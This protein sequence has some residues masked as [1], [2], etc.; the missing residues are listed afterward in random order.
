MKALVRS[1][2]VLALIAAAG[3]VAVKLRGPDVAGGGS[4]PQLEHME[5]RGLSFVK[6]TEEVAVAADATRATVDFPF[7]NKTDR[8]LTIAKVEKNC[9]CAEVQVSGGKLSYAPGEQGV[10]RASYELG[11]L[12]G[13]VEKPLM[14]WLAGDP[15]KEPS[16]TLTSC[17][18]IPV[19]VEL[20]RKTLEWTL[21]GPGEPAKITIRCRHL[22]P[23]RVLAVTSSS[24]D[25]KVALKPVAEGWH[26][27]L[28]VTP[29]TTAN[30]GLACIRM[31]TDCAIPRW[32]VLQ[33]FATVRAPTANLQ[34]PSAP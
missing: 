6:T 10:V 17:L 21:G 24:D 16:H 13:R 27:E 26:Y 23:I 19:L 4:P 29:A 11:N 12:S 1:L 2:I 8:V 7:E 20:D 9:S 31:E 28:S 30:P 33:A 32:K 3:F 25:F 14:L 5:A 34:A 18:I 22:E 15:D